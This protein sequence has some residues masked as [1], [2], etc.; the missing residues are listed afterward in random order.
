M[1]IDSIRS[2]VILDHI[3]AG[4]GLRIYHD[5]NLDK[6]ACSV[7][8]IKNVKSQKMGRK[9]IIKIDDTIELNLEN[10]A[11]IDPSITVTIVTDST[12]KE[13]INLK[14]P[15]KVINIQKCK[16]PRCI[17]SVEQELAHVFLLTDSDKGT[18]RCQY[19]E[20]VAQR[21]KK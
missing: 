13:K 5:L 9:D 10:L 4:M 8:I 3:Q 18:Y 20:A 6:L 16:N 15:E 17:T 1:N 7:A 2:G 14:Q 21:E 11:Y 19:C 12:V